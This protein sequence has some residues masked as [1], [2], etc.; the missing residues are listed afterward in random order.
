M[1]PGLICFLILLT[2]CCSPAHTG[3]EQADQLLE[4]YSKALGSKSAE[5]VSELFHEDAQILAEGKPTVVGRSDIRAHFS[6]LESIDFEES[7]EILDML[8]SE[9]YIILQTRNSGNWKNPE[10]GESG[11][12]EVKGLFVLSPDKEGTLKILKYAYSGNGD[13][14]E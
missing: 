5:Q 8:T 2:F 10:S 6:G 13:S 11:S 1:R 7:F 3:S 12:F 14:S 4:D 9:D